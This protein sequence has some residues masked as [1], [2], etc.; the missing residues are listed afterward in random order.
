M[1]SCIKKMKNKHF[2]LASSLLTL[3]L[4][5]GS[6]SSEGELMSGSPD[7]SVPDNSNG[8]RIVVHT[9]APDDIVMSRALHDE[10]EYTV[11]KLGVYLFVADK[12]NASSD[13]NYTLAYQA[14]NLV[15]GGGDGQFTDNG[16]GSLSYTLPIDAAWLGMSAKIALIANDKVSEGLTTTAAAPATAT[17]L[18]AFKKS[19]ATNKLTANDQSADIISGSIYAT[20][21]TNATGLPMTAMAKVGSEEA[22]D[23]TPLGADLTASLQRIMARIDVR[24][25]TPNLTITSMKVENAASQGYLFPQTG[26]AA[27]ADASYYSLS[28]TSGYTSKL[29]SG[30]AY[31]AN[32]SDNNTLKHVFYLYEQENTESRAAQVV[33]GYK[34]TIGNKEKEGSV[35]VPLKTSDAYIPTTRNNLYTISLGSGDP[36]QDGVMVTNLVVND[37]EATTG[38]TGELQPGKGDEGVVPGDPKDLSKLAVGDYYMMDG[39]V[40]DKDIIPEAAYPYVIG[41]VFQTDPSRIGQAEKDALTQ[42]G[43]SVPHGLVMAVKMV[44]NG[45]GCH[46]KDE[47]TDEAGLDYKSTVAACYSDISGLSN[48]NTVKGNDNNFAHHPAFKAV[49]DFGNTV[50][51]PVASTG[52]FLPSVGQLWDMVE[53]L[54]G[55][56][57]EMKKQHTNSTSHGFY[58]YYGSGTNGSDKV[59]MPMVTQTAQNH[60]N[61]YLI[62][63]VP[64]YADKIDSDTYLSSSE[65]SKSN[66]WH[67]HFGTSY[68]NVCSGGSKSGNN[69]FVRAILAF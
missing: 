15:A 12:S 10:P 69:D 65:Y 54:G 27:P 35:S 48:Y 14:P 68:F 38:I 2:V 41:V 63:L 5:L 24:N 56:P 60:M 17:T 46:W 52:W 44:N 22:F 31:D 39:T 58:F 50:P 37:W 40:R 32:T 9:P 62:H 6:C 36:I 4:G 1:F 18:E 16:N 61:Q 23:I 19:I 28:P 43:V 67:I 42:K 29:S 25:N 66:I 45:S 7:S 13:A 30:I 20:D 49:S 11:K 51:A 33:I 53:N 64:L 59:Y 8:I 26:T 55:F 34:L 57:E 47:G 3:L 21:D